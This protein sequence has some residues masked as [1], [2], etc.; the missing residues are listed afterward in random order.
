MTFDSA[1]HDLFPGLHPTNDDLITPNQTSASVADDFF[2]FTDSLPEVWTSSASSIIVDVKRGSSTAMSD[3][4]TDASNETMQ[5]RIAE[6][7]VHKFPIMKSSKS[8]K[9][10]RK[11][12]QTVK[13]KWMDSSPLNSMP[14]PPLAVP[15]QEISKEKRLGSKHMAQNALPNPP[16][17]NKA[18]PGQYSFKPIVTRDINSLPAMF[19]QGQLAKFFEMNSNTAPISRV[20]ENILMTIA[21]QV[22]V[23]NSKRRNSAPSAVN[24][25][26]SSLTGMRPPTRSASE[27]FVIPPSEI[28]AEIR[29]DQQMSDWK[30]RRQMQQAYHQIEALVPNDFY[31]KPTRAGILMGAVDYIRCLKETVMRLETQA[32]SNMEYRSAQ[33]KF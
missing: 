6:T 26:P 23:K 8:R 5:S 17:S 3:V 32:Q 21:P 31:T 10:G 33:K 2:G 28:P 15:Y 9:S 13:D 29:T 25:F 24:H 12:K 20:P 30:R 27:P 7:P 14:T 22:Q 16:I 19:Q 1:W 4:S 18:S 11:N